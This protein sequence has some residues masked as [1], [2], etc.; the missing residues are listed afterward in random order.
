MEW[1]DAVEDVEGDDKTTG[2]CEVSRGSY[3]GKG[4][5]CGGRT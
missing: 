4:V 5:A 3:M 2:G 1:F